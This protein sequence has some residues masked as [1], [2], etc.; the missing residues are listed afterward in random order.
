MA[1]YTHNCHQF[2]TQKPGLYS[3][4]CSNESI[5]KLQTSP[6]KFT[7]AKRAKNGDYVQSAWSA[8]D[9]RR[10][11]ST[12]ETFRSHLAA[13]DQH[14]P[15]S[16]ATNPPSADALIENEI[17]GRRL[18]LGALEHMLKKD[19]F[20][21]DL[22]QAYR[23]I[24]RY[25]TKH[26]KYPK[27]FGSQPVLSLWDFSITP[28][29][30]RTSA[31]QRTPESTTR[32][33]FD[34]DFVE[35]EDR[36][37]TI[38]YS[39]PNV[40]IDVRAFGRVF[41]RMPAD[42][43]QAHM[44]QWCENYAKLIA[45]A[46]HDHLHH[47]IL[48]PGRHSHAQFAQKPLTQT[49]Q[50]YPLPT[51]LEQEAIAQHAH[52]MNYLFTEEKPAHDSKGNPVLQPDG[53][54]KTIPVGARRKQRVLELMAEQMELVA[55]AQENALHYATNDKERGLIYEAS[56]YLSELS[57][58]RFFRIL[59]PDDLS[60]HEEVALRKSGVRTSVSAQCDRIGLLVAPSGEVDHGLL[61]L[62]E[63]CETYLGQTYAHCHRMQ[64]VPYYPGNQHREPRSTLT[65]MF[66]DPHEM[67]LTHV[68]GRTIETAL[69]V[70][71]RDWQKQHAQTPPT[72]TLT[73][74]TGRTL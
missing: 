19:G 49:F 4:V 67:P 15:E 64:T 63:L 59:P 65:S 57:A 69:P 7:D 11:Y 68:L 72:D 2:V 74:K 10:Y 52:T 44:Q 31:N 55:D 45:L 56:T 5:M 34:Y 38:R 13:P 9:T 35:Y 1:R 32:Y 33:G 43:A 22:T 62:R 14:F 50:K 6:F 36:T 66:A 27:L 3:I 40:R 26:K 61:A 18:Y 28:K 53:T 29:K 39:V 46:E 51:L 37:N 23:D 20:D 58:H 8:L 16:T 73:P 70:M 41:S 71:K 60:F 12:Q 47:L 17:V 30:E 42:V 24:A 21:I 54:P 25:S 48:I